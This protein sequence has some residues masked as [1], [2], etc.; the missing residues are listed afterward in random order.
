[1]SKR[2]Y[3]MATVLG[4]VPYAFLAIWGD[5]EKGTM[6]FYALFVLG[7]TGLPSSAGEG[8]PSSPCWAATP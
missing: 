1:M 7:V 3:A 4:C 8:T 2:R 6:A 5:A